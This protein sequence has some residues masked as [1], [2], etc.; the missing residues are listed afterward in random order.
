MNHKLA[1]KNNLTWSNG[2]L[3]REDREKLHGH[4]GAVIWFTG[5]SASG[6]STIAR[7][8]EKQLYNYLGLFIL[9]AI[10]PATRESAALNFELKNLNTRI[11]EQKIL[12]P[13]YENLLKKAQ[14]KPPER[15]ESIEK[16]KLK[17]GE[18]EAVATMLRDMAGSSKLNLVEFSPKV[19]TIISGAGVLMIDFMLKGE[20]I[21]LQ[22]F[23]LQLCQTPYLEQIEQ[24][25][26][27]SVRDT[28]EIRIRIWLAY[29]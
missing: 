9:L 8:L 22:P 15:I 7:H 28:N 17:R 4:K 23:L 13:V 12:S 16:K 24:I 20:F 25:R 11:E 29:E 10:M 19:E 21:N 18:T 6:K 3:T 14:L 27:R 2:Y 1:E 5:L 26:I